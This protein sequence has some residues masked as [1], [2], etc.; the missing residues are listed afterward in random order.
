[1][2]ERVGAYYYFFPTYKQGKKILWEGMDRDGF[3]FMDHFPKELRK[4]T[5]NTEL[6]I[7]ATNGSIFQIIGTDNIDSVVG[8][9][10]VGCVFS[11]YAL[12]DPKAWDYIRPIL[13]ENG[14]WAVFNFT[15]RG[16]NHGKDI[17]EMAQKSKE[18]FCERLTVDDT[19]AIP[20]NIL[21]QE[22]REIA[23]KDGTDSLYQQEYYCSFEEPVQGAYY[24]H[25]MKEAI[26]RITHVPYAPETLVNTYW[27]LGVG[28]S[29]SIWFQQE[30]AQEIRMIDY[31]ETSGEGLAHYRNIL[32]ERG[33]NYGI[34][35]APHDI[36]VR[37]LGTGK[38]RKETAA[39]LGLDFKVAPKLPIDDGIDAARNIL[40]KTW[41]N[42]VKCE[43]GIN[44]LRN[45]HKEYDEK[46][47][48]YKN[49]P[50][51]DWSTH[52]ADAFR[53][54][55]VSHRKEEPIKKQDF[56]AWE[57]GS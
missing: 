19:K 35:Y 46:N 21:E 10:P 24:G 43:K 36:E 11:E 3:K 40:A 18:W 7:E 37:E 50:H 56:K 42:K 23:S 34:H 27:D 31:Y 52:G 1:M 54:F 45:Y 32:Q 49:R 14:G 16:D 51:H 41:F 39:G 15:P 29:T 57:I 8:T 48:T 47:K 17:F 26:N 22:L 55:A 44:A 28:D 9:N 30:T 4:R 20:K 12:Q 38:S 33:Y 13:A 2:F 5:D 25:Q 53:Y 6:L